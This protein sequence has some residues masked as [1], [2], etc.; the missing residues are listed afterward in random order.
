M[1]HLILVINALILGYHSMGM[2][3]LDLIKK[4]RLYAVD[5]C[6]SWHQPAVNYSVNSDCVLNFFE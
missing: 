4:Q 3:N 5:I 2:P 1:M 6:D